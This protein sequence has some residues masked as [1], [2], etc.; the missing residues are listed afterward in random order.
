MVLIV[1]CIFIASGAAAADPAAKEPGVNRRISRI[2]TLAQVYPTDTLSYTVLPNVQ[3]LVDAWVEYNTQTCTL[4]SSGTWTVTT[5]P[6]YGVTATGIVD[7]MLGNGDCPGTTFP[8]G[9]I[10]YTWTST[11][12]NAATDSFAATWMSPDFS[13]QDAVTLTLATVTI[14]SA[15]L[16]N[17]SIPVTITGPSAA[18]GSLSLAI[19]GANNT[20]T[21]MYNNGTAVAPGSYTVTL[22]RP[23]MVQDM[24]SSIVATWNASTPPVKSTS[25]TITPDWNVRGIVQN[26]VYLKVYETACSGNPT[27]GF[28]TFNAHGCAFTAVDFKP[29]FASQTYINGTGETSAG[30]LVH[31]NSANLCR[32]HYPPGANSHNTF[33]NVSSVTGSCGNDLADTNVAAYPNPA[34]GGGTYACDDQLLYVVRNTNQNASFPNLVEDYC[35]AC[36]N[37]SVGTQD[38][39]DNYFDQG[40]CTATGLPNYWEADLGQSGAEIRIPV[41]EGGELEPDNTAAAQASYRDSEITVESKKVNNSLVLSIASKGGSS[42]VDLPPEVFELQ[43]IRRYDDRIIVIG[44]VGASVSRVMMVNVRDGVISDSF[45]AY[46]PVVSPDGRFIAFVKFYPPHFV[47]GTEDHH[48]LYDMTKS[49]MANRPAGIGRDDRVDVGLNVYPGNGNKEGDNIGV[50]DKLAHGS[51]SLIFWSPDSTKLAF[52]DQATLLKL[53]LVNVPDAGSAPGTSVMPLNR[54]AVCAA[55]LSANHC[56]AYLDKVE[57]QETGLEA[58]FSGGGTNGA[59]HRELTVK[60]TDFVPSR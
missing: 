57:F 14:Q 12:P 32:T 2:V 38:H 16:V 7:G 30:T 22:N 60:Y 5:P 23:M 26:T 27:S 46:N 24:Y 51:P 41:A 6:V 44:D 31:S 8:F 1:L 17:N 52:A 39:V 4:I 34:N 45:D 53:V 50:P 18:T 56:D 49:A 37:H 55:P 21:A 15:D 29:M 13:V 47:A 48:M 35:P 11:D 28:W 3:I 59:I 25:F 43:G 19:Q 33:Y 54:T 36:R 42:D 20:F 10:F 9:A 58:H 40:T